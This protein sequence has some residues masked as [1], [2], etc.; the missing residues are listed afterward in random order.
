ME[1]KH[2]GSAKR[3]KFRVQKS[4]GKAL[5]SVFLNNRGVSKIDYLDNGRQITG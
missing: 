3:K 2:S 4:D 5:A 1:S